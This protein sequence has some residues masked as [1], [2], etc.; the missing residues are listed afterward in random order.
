MMIPIYFY[1]SNYYLHYV[2]VLPL[3]I[4]YSEENEKKRQLWGLVSFV[5]LVVCVSEYWGFDARG[6]DERYAQWSVGAL[7]GFLV[8][9]IALARDARK[10]PEAESPSVS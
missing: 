10:A 8:I 2:F 5:L 3:M 1:P 6:V 9:F 4:D 7:I